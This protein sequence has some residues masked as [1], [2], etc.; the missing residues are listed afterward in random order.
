MSKSRALINLLTYASVRVKIMGIVV[1]LVLILGLFASAQNYFTMQTT[2]REQLIKQ[3][4][5]LG[6]YAAAR[7]VDLI[8]TNDSF[9]LH[10]LVT[11]IVENNEDVRYVLIFDSEGHLV[12]NSFGMLLPQGLIQSNTVIEHEAYNLEILK[13]EEGL[14]YDLALPIF[15]NRA[16]TVRLGMTEREIQKLLLKTTQGLLL[17]TVLV[18]FF[19]I[20]AA[21][22]LTSV[23][24]KPIN[25]M[26]EITN[27]V[28]KGD[29]TKRVKFWWIQ[30]EFFDL[31]KAFNNM[32]ENLQKAHDARSNLLNK[33]IGAQEEERSRIA[34]ELH[35]HMGQSLTSLMIGLKMLESSDNIDDVRNKVGDLR[36]IANNTIEDM[37]SLAF[38]L[39]PSLL[40]DLGLEAAVHRYSQ[41]CLASLGVDVDFQAI[42]ITGIELPPEIKL[43][44]Y[45]IVQE[46]LT[47]I[48]KYSRATEASVIIEKR[49]NKLMAIIEDNGVGFDV[50]KIFN[51]SIKEKKLGL[52]GM[53]ERA[54]LLGGQLTIEST[55][56][57]GTTIYLHI[58]LEGMVDINEN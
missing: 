57:Q 47:N 8:F 33:I 4:I 34:R 1:G 29:F 25:H 11:N 2:L 7:S 53:W 10:Q 28:G 24:T 51:S 38:A 19:G 16:G 14:V 27:A 21:Y 23:L 42:G 52:H 12:A 6:Q 48:A 39:R 13:T 41:E 45:R 9:A 5:S 35:D 36:H 56:G 58:N 49:G 30:D 15:D 31:G 37:R 3:G 43:T 46:A 54:N 22:F 18:G 20:I 44:I 32:I 55:L 26:V 50:E 17:T 40:D